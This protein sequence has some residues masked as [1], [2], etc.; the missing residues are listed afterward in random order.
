MACNST[1]QLCWQIQIFAGTGIKMN[2]RTKN[3]T[4]YFC[5]SANIIDVLIC[6]IKKKKK[7]APSSDNHKPSNLY[8]HGDKRE[9]IFVFKYKTLQADFFFSNRSKP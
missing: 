5:A 2:N 8:L 4:S 6:N 9:A 7:I 1:V 3:Y